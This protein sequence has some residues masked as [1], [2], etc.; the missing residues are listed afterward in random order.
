MWRWS[1][2]DRF[3]R[4]ALA[5]ELGGGAAPALMLR[6][7]VARPDGASRVNQAQVL[8]VDARFWQMAPGAASDLP[9]DE[10]AL[11]E[12]AA[13]QLGVKAGETVIV[14]VEKPGFFSKDAPLSGEENEVVAIRAKVARIVTDAEFGRFAL[15]ASQVPPCDGLR[16]AGDAAAAAGVRG[17]GESAARSLILRLDEPDRQNVVQL[18]RFRFAAVDEQR[19]RQ[20]GASTAIGGTFGR[21]A[22]ALATRRRQPRNPQARNRRRRAAHPARL[23]RSRHRRRRADAAWTRSPISSTNC[24][25]ARRRC[26]IR[27]SPRSM[28]R[29]PAFSRRSSMTTRS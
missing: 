10:I 16:A 17:A 29:R 4:A 25:R 18:G 11:N 19:P 6:G 2:G 24:A 7:S 20:L 14:R 23:P 15:Q 21:V 22:E 1:G 9:P 28:R 13:A 8:G 5:D 26:R 3:F 27:W 12:R